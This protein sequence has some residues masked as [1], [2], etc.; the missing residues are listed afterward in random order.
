MRRRISIRGPVRR[1]VRRSVHRSV[2]P[3]LFS[4]VKS[5]HTR[6]ILYRVSGLVSPFFCSARGLSLNQTDAYAAV[7][8][9][10]IAIVVVILFSLLL[11]LTLPSG[12]LRPRSRA[13]TPLL[14]TLSLNRVCCAFWRF[15]SW[16][17]CLALAVHQTVIRIQTVLRFYEYFVIL[18]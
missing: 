11:L 1:F 10:V 17:S 8:V 4:K 3:V 5:A 12:S 14:F 13:L 16:H 9:V 7:V 2:C 6:R 15:L 18:I